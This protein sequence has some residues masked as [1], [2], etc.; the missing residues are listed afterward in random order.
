MPII[1]RP[2]AD[3][4]IAGTRDHPTR[5]HRV[6][7]LLLIVLAG[8]E[9]RA[10]AAEAN[11]P[12]RGEALP[13]PFEQ[14]WKDPEFSK[15][16]LG[17]DTS[18]E[19]RVNAV[20]QALYKSLDERKLLAEN[21][22]KAIEELEPKIT[23]ASSPLLSYSLATLYFREGDSTNAIRH[24][25]VA[26]KKF[27]KF[28]R[29]QK[30]LGFALAREGRFRE[31]APHLTKALELGG[32]DA[33]T[34]GLL[35]YCYLNLE[36]HISAEAAYQYALLHDPEN[37][38]WRLGLVR[39]LAVSGKP[40]RAVDLLDELLQEHPGR[41]SLW[42]FQAN[43]YLQLED[44]RK[45]AVNLEV[46]R[47]LGKATPRNL[48]TLGDIYMAME[49]RELALAAYLEA[50][51]QDADRNVS[52]ALRA[53]EILTNRGAWEEAR[54]LFHQVRTVAGTA[55]VDDEEMKLLRLE[56]KLAMGTGEGE[57]AIQTLEAILTRNP[58]DGESLL[59]AGDYYAKTD[60]PEKAEL[61]YQMAGQ[62][63]DY[64]AESCVKRS[65]LL[66]RQRKYNEAIELLRKAQRLKPREHVQQF[67]EKVE[68][69]AARSTRS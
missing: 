39:S 32:A 50:V 19:P 64:E 42:V 47:R 27:P 61:R 1:P 36:K 25:Q 57:K 55:L 49:A 23:E 8:I 2:Q 21:P 31:A 14:L 68:V 40:E 37:L 24:Y 26:V 60:Q 3:V 38:D 16:Y 20:E 34:Y 62:L 59:L 13:N 6:L 48:Y 12:D 7:A 53:A 11:A 44:N 30:N 15:R 10:F 66:V 29:A 43:L 46:V 67:L 18:L 54:K 5:L 52:R 69:A 65:Q 58:L 35:G 45:A 63:S 56:S 17:Y 41:E 33:A 51:Q 9:G 28:M 22:R 4:R